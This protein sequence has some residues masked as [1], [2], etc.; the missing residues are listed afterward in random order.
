MSPTRKEITNGGLFSCSLLLFAFHTSGGTLEGLWYQFNMQ[1]KNSTVTRRVINHVWHRL[2]EKGYESEPNLVR[3][4]GRYV[5]STCFLQGYAYN[6]LGLA[7]IVV[8]HNES[9]W[10]PYHSSEAFC[11]AVEC[12]G[13]F[14]IETARADLK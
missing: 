8:E 5:K 1:A 2:V 4:P 3:I 12:Y 11:H 6:V 10:Y 9:R 13:N 14:L 7:N